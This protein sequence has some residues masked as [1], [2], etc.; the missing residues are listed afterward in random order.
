MTDTSTTA[1]ADQH[2]PIPAANRH[3]LGYG[4]GRPAMLHETSVI[5]TVTASHVIGVLL[6]ECAE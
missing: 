6:S 3:V 2:R 5:Q 1:A 4:T